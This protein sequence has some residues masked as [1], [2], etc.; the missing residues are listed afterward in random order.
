MTLTGIKQIEKKNKININLF[1]YDTEKKS[2]YPV[3]IS[4]ESYDDHLEL[5]YLEGKNELGEKLLIMSLS[6]I[7]ID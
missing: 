1:G 3:Q 2:I 6:K 5:L 4:E 7:L